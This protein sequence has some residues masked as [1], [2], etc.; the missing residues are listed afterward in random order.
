M[1]CVRIQVQ[2]YLTLLC[3]VSFTPLSPHPSPP[4][5]TLPSGQSIP[6]SNGSPQTCGL[7]PENIKK[8]RY[9]NIIPCK[10]A[11]LLSTSISLLSLYLSSCLFRCGD[12]CASHEFYPL[13]LTCCVNG[14][15]WFVCHL[16]YILALMSSCLSRHYFLTLP[17]SLSLIYVNLN[18]SIQSF[19]P[20][21]SS[22]LSLSLSLF[23]PSLPLLTSL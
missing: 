21:H 8:N 2:L 12:V 5:P 15:C 17:V 13:S 19:T 16:Q 18:L 1:Y 11:L 9:K 7:L 10:F 22:S 4:F 20:S 23:S 14:S 6:M 3:L